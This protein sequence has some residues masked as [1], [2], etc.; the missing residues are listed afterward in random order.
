MIVFYHNNYSITEI[1]SAETGSIP[2]DIHRNI[3]P[4]LLDFADE[5]KDE[6]LVWC[7]ESEKENLNLIAIEKLFHHNKF[8]LSYNPNSKIILTDVWVI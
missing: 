2:H 7:H 6:I 8:L 5:F 3:V 4:A 1:V